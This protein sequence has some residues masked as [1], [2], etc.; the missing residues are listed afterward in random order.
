MTDELSFRYSLV[1]LALKVQYIAKIFKN[2]FNSLS[3][4]YLDEPPHKLMY[5][6]I[7]F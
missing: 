2:L 4:Q 1:V 7:N 6:Q 3:L 5:N